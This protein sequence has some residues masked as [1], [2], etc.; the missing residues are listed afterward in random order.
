M[1]MRFPEATGAIELLL[2]RENRRISGAG[3]CVGFF[4]SL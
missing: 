3:R 4:P 2:L 1:F